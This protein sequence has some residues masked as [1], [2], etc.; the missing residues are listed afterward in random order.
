MDV[1]TRAFIRERAG[2]AC[3][4]CR[5]SQEYQP[6]YHFHVEHVRPK[7]HG[8]GDGVEN[9]ALACQQCNLHKGTNL[10]GI[11]PESQEITA[12]FNPR[13]ERW[14]DH[15]ER[16]GVFIRGNTNVGRATVEALC[17]NREDRVELRRHL[18]MLGDG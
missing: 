16:H 13:Q 2:N 14:S 9:L 12:I 18:M 5:L 15:F 3:E 1:A 4:Y 8:G 6:A 11:D 7:K 10:S 17:M